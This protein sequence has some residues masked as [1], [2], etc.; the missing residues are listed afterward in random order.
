MTDKKTAIYPGSFDPCTFGHLDVIK[1]ASKLFDELIILVAVNSN[2][3]AEFT[4]QQRSDHI[5]E[6]CKD[7]PNVK[8]AY[9]EG[10]LVDAVDEFKACAVVRGLRS[11]SDFEYEIHMAMVNR[12][13][14]PE[15]ETA[16]LMPSPETSF[17]SSRMI[18]EIAKLGGDINKFVP[19]IIAQALKEKYNAPTSPS[20]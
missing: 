1:R 10:L 5:R 8:V 19:D 18:R 20:N 17:V 7:M 15:C 2:K 4:L 13:L 11:I 16:F 6:I 14:N 3:N 12:D 9:I